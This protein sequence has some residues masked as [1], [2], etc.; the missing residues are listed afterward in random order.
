MAKRDSEN[1][2]KRKFS[3]GT[4]G[5]MLRDSTGTYRPCTYA[6]YLKT[7]DEMKYRY[8]S[9][10]YAVGSRKGPVKRYEGK[11]TDFYDAYVMAY[12]QRNKYTLDRIVFYTVKK[13]VNG[14][15]YIIKPN[16]RNSPYYKDM[17][18]KYR[19]RP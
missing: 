19:L 5:F 6:T 7:V 2:V 16:A 12:A 14:K 9:I 8:F 15:M 1:Y 11:I 4:R 18:A 3:P 13:F 17:K 10:S